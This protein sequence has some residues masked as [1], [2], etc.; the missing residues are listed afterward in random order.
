V[1]E[2]GWPLS[3][4]GAAAPNGCGNP[5]LLSSKMK[6][7]LVILWRDRVVRVDCAHRIRVMRG[8]E[9]MLDVG[10]HGVIDFGHIRLVVRDPIVTYVFR[11]DEFVESCVA[12][13]HAR[14]IESLGED[15]SSWSMVPAQVTRQ[16]RQSRRIVWDRASMGAAVICELEVSQLGYV[17][18]RMGPMSSIGHSV[19]TVVIGLGGQMK[20]VIGIVL[21]GVDFRIGDVM[22]Q[23]CLEEEG[24]TITRAAQRLSE[25]AAHD[26]VVICGGRLH[27]GVFTGCG[28]GLLRDD[29]ASAG[30]WGIGDHNGLGG[31]DDIPVK[32]LLD[33]QRV[34]RVAVVGECE[35]AVNISHAERVGSDAPTRVGI[36]GRV[37]AGRYRR[38]MRAATRKTYCY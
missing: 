22:V 8:I 19:H 13:H 35:P 21:G 3:F 24:G 30:D 15:L 12:H 31:G 34:H 14:D 1:R 37:V 36:A 9:K 7:A 26:D 5:E 38:V 6:I 11:E 20:Q 29:R 23:V 28:R 18:M 10:R 25:R 33:R 4:D 32:D 17:R 27:R 2:Y 16:R